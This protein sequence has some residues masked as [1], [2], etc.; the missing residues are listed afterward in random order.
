MKKLIALA[1]LVLFPMFVFA[2]TAG[3]ISGTVTGEDGTP[4]AG[5]NVLVVGT[6][7]GAATDENGQFYILDVPVGQYAIRAEYIGYTS[8]IMENVRVS[9]DL[10]T[11]VNFVLSVAAVEGEAVTVTA[12]RP[13]IQKNA[14]NTNRIIDSEVIEALPMRGVENIV[15]LQSGVVDGHVRG[16]RTGDN[17]Y[18][19]DGVLVRNV[20]NGE[21]L[22]NSITQSGTEEVSVQT[23]GFSAEYGNANGGVVNVTSKTGGSKFS[24][25]AEIITDI[26]TTDPGS[27][28]NALYSYGYNLLSF[29]LGGP[30]TNNLRFYVNVERESRLDDDPSAAS[31]PHSEYKVYD[32]PAAL[33]ADS[34]YVW[35]AETPPN[36][37]GID[38]DGD[39]EIDE[40]GEITSSNALNGEEGVIHLSEF[41]RNNHTNSSEL[42]DF[43]A[44]Y[45][46]L[47]IDTV[48]KYKPA[49]LDTTFV[50]VHNYQQLY[51]PKRNNE[52]Q[53]LRAT[54]NL[55][56]D[57]KPLRLKIGGTIFDNSTAQYS[58]LD[59]LLNWEN[60]AQLDTRLRLG[61]V[62]GT[63]TLSPKSFI[64]STISMKNYSIA[65]YNPN[66]SDG[67]YNV[68]DE[69]EIMKYGKRTTDLG[70]PNYYYRDQG[71]D[72]LSIPSLVQFNGLGE[73][74]DNYVK[75]SES[76]MGIRTDYVNQLSV[77][78][79]KAGFEYY[80]TEV[81]YYSLNQALE[82]YENVAKFDEKPVT[83]N[84]DGEISAAE[85]GDYNGD[86]TEDDTDFLD[87]RYA[88]YRNA[89]TFNLGYNIFGEETDEYK[90]DD[91]SQEPGKA[92]QTRFFV[93]DK[94]ELSD[95]VVNLGLSFESFNPNTY[96]PD[97]DGDGV[98]DDA[99][100]DN[101]HLKDGRI[102]RSGDQ[103][104]SYKW[105]PVETHTT[106]QPR[107]GFAFPVTDKT[108]FHAQYGRY[109]QAP[110]L[111]YLYL[112]DSR[113]ASNL[114]QGNMTESPNPTLEPEKTTSYEI[115][116]TQQ[117]GQSA[118]L[119]ITGFYKEVRDYLMLRNREEA[120]Q[121][122]SE[123]SWAQFMNG[124][125]GV[126]QG[127]SF[128][129]RMRRVNG[130]LADVNY[131]LMWARGTG[132]DP[133]SNFDIA[134][135][136]DSYPVTINRLDFDQR[137][138][139]SIMVDYRSPSRSGLLSNLGANAVL[140]FGS[141]QAYTPSITQ[142]A[143]FSRGWDAP[144]AAINSGD[145]PWTSSLDLRVDK[146]ISLDG[147]KLNA[148]VWI[149]NALNMENAQN[150]YPSS[151]EPGEDGYLATDEGKTWI[152]GQTTSYP[153]A[154]AASLYKDRLNTP[155][156]YGI[157]RTVRFGIQVN[158]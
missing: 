83:G 74:Y 47:N 128:N 18:Y 138:T 120:L 124:D 126:T 1:A 111:F 107:V 103:D 94:I 98:G 117:I 150:V 79:I 62:N 39:G 31:F 48:A 127:F 53:V 19:I 90:A 7:Y 58:H 102:D 143:V 122:G 69:N 73:Q 59:Q 88:T 118:A 44:T 35:T 139:G 66:F 129:L 68:I 10:T 14:T 114:T 70:T 11:E 28:Q 97:S 105:E 133:S 24:G 125:F 43:A 45:E 42:A 95:V 75:R 119:D 82:I 130:F 5:A 30:I 60:S 27:E 12:E 78:E 158:I 76:T 149:L 41:I 21:N 33:F 13:I 67:E 132:S 29:D 96:A 40:W 3:K 99:G 55:I 142:S 135:T 61:Y 9:A 157:P 112:S 140:R 20:W 22:T 25:S 152:Q 32:S 104:G 131:T 38:N 26:G 93:S 110:P 46:T 100:F 17:A 52:S 101:I 37:D 85:L 153:T 155:G 91:H 36:A 146:G 108:V 106:L 84:F 156:R 49:W 121:N 72:V 123:F 89:Y 86:G 8:T 71:K 64:R 23:G 51:G 136:G 147:V 81:R 34:A 137:H 4:L 144:I 115:G 56:F 134:W 87:W 63:F 57:L 141:G 154:P 145:L 50:A 113:L 109:W 65:D 151:G 77:H 116:F 6:S 80:N 92:I 54:G 15:D 2:Q 16:G 148:Y